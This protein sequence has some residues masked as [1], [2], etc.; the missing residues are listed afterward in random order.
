MLMPGAQPRT[1]EQRDLQS[2]WG[3]EDYGINHQN[4]GGLLLK[5]QER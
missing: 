4:L 1:Q 3:Q 5:K 2:L